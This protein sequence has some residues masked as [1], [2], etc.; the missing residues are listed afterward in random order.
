MREEGYKMWTEKK[1]KENIVIYRLISSGRH[2]YLA[3]SPLIAFL[4]G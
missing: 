3:S 4:L 2:I 1:G